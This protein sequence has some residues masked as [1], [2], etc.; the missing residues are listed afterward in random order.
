MEAHWLLTVL[1]MLADVLGTVL[2]YNMLLWMFGRP[3]DQGSAISSFNP[4]ADQR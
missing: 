1:N 4:L 2:S 3:G